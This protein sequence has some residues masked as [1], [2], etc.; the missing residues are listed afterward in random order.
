MPYRQYSDEG[1]MTLYDG[2]IIDQDFIIEW[3][4]GQI[5]C[6]TFRLHF[7]TVLFYIKQNE[8]METPN[9][10]VIISKGKVFVMGDNR[11]NSADSRCSEIGLI[12]I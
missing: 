4:V 2:R 3:F 6:Y 7:V 11:N 5:K 1:Y 9:L 8:E 10:D 12:D